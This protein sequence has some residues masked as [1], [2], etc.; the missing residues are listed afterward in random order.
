MSKTIWD[1]C[2]HQWLGN[3]VVT[4]RK[5]FD[6]WRLRT[7]TLIHNLWEE[8][9]SLLRVFLLQASFHW[10]PDDFIFHTWK[11]FL[12]FCPVFFLLPVDISLEIISINIDGRHIFHLKLLLFYKLGLTINM[13]LMIKRKLIWNLVITGPAD[14]TLCLQRLSLNTHRNPI[15]LRLFR[16]KVSHPWGLT[17]WRDSL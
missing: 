13:L 9:L 15:N 4:S 7:Y 17:F 16:D 6:A 12:G 1:G 10:L 14:T 2:Y 8:L 3:I 5:L 11:H